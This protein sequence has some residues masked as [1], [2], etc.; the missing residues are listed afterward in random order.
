ML[1]SR[2]RHTL[3]LGVGNAVVSCR[4]LGETAQPKKASGRGGQMSHMGQEHQP[5]EPGEHGQTQVP[6]LS[7]TPAAVKMVKQAITQKGA[8]D[9]GLRMTVAGGGCKGFQY[10]LNLEQTTRAEDALVVQDGITIYLDPVSAI[11]LKGTRLDYVTNRHGTGFHFF[12]LDV[13]RT[14]GCG[15]SI[16]LRGCIK[17]NTRTE[18]CVLCAQRPLMEIDLEAAID[19]VDSRQSISHPGLTPMQKCEKCCFIICQCDKAA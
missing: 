7:L 5:G 8:E 12:G 4:S 13:E 18:G 15:S 1:D 9:C 11:H 2:G 10:S 3:V 17:N 14:I 6:L 19:F 16:L